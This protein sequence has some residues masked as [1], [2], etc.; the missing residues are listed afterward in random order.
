MVH[1]CDLDK[2]EQSIQEQIFDSQ[3]DLD[4]VEYR[5]IRKDGQIRWVEDYGHFIHTQNL[6]D[7]F[8]VF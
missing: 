4:Y 5:I 2:I 3:Y 8:Y 1:P 7:I 6:G